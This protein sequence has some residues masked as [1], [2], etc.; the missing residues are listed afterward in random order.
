MNAA[1]IKICTKIGRQQKWRHSAEA[2]SWPKNLTNQCGKWG[3]HSRKWKSPG[4]YRWPRKWKRSESSWQVCLKY[5]LVFLSFFYFPYWNLVLLE[6]NIF[7]RHLQSFIA[8]IGSILCDK[9]E[10]KSYIDIQTFDCSRGRDPP[11]VTIGYLWNSEK[12]RRKGES[13][14][15]EVPRKTNQN[16]RGN[17][18][19]KPIFRAQ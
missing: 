2:S 5:F 14:G 15:M 12:C 7:L 4:V 19:T 13:N 17:L 9:C 8:V 16:R 18:W 11:S 6:V 3:C 1:V 10:G